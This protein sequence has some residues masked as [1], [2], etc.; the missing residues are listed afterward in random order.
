MTVRKQ[1][2]SASL[3]ILRTDSPPAMRM[4][5]SEASAELYLVGRPGLFSSFFVFIRLP[6]ARVLV[7]E[8]TVRCT[9]VGFLFGH[10]LYLVKG[11]RSRAYYTNYCKDIQY[12]PISEVVITFPWPL[13]LTHAPLFRTQKV[14]IALRA[15]TVIRHHLAIKTANLR[16]SVFVSTS[17]TSVF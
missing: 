6:R 11:L 14:W 7:Q 13:W 4:Q 10:C 12:A 8:Y 9:H 16:S 3:Q 17:T 5:I 15:A 1:G 2:I